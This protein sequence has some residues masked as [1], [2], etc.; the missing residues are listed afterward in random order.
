MSAPIT[1][2]LPESVALVRYEVV[3]SLAAYG[4]V[5]AAHIA[6]SANTRDAWEMLLAECELLGTRRSGAY[7]R[8]ELARACAKMARGLVDSAV[9]VLADH[10]GMGVEEWEADTRR[11]MAKA[12]RS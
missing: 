1:Y 12:V 10:C 4:R 8:D 3:A 6:R 9:K 11:E 7:G 2:D 5:C